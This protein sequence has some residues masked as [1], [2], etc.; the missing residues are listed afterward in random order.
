VHDAPRHGVALLRVERH[1]VG[2]L[3]VDEQPSFE[4]EEE[5]VLDGVLVPVEVAVDDAEAD[6]RVVD[7]RERLVEP[8]LVRGGL[9]AHVDECALAELLVEVDVVVGHRVVSAS[10]ATVI[11]RMSGT[12]SPAATSTP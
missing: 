10:M 8:R 5:L 7:R 2:A 12:S 4:D 6:D 9:R 11:A 1:R 3:D